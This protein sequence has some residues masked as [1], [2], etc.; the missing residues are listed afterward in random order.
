MFRAENIPYLDT[1]TV[2]T[3]EGITTFFAYWQHNVKGKAT[4]KAKEKRT[5]SWL[6]PEK[7]EKKSPAPRH[8][9]V[10]S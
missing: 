3:E 5:W 10:E 6:K 9:F 8:Y 7:T 1:S 2:P 4:L